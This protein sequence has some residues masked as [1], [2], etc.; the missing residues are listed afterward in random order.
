MTHK[1]DPHSDT[2]QAV[3]EWIE[4]GRGE[5][6][7]ALIADQKSEQQRG[8]IDIL[9]ALRKLPDTDEAPAIV[10]DNYT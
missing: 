3:L 7:E 10:S 9:D 1:I 4:A 8:K 6:V 5:A 2:W